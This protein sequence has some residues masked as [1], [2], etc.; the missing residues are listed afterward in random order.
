MADRRDTR[1]SYRS[2]P[3][4]RD[5][6]STAGSARD[7]ERAWEQR[8]Y[9]SGLEN[10]SPNERFASSTRQPVSPRPVV[11]PVRH[12]YADSSARYDVARNARRNAGV[13]SNRVRYGTEQAGEDFR[14]SQ[15]ARTS[16]QDFGNQYFGRDGSPNMGSTR[17]NR[18]LI[19]DSSL[20]MD[21][22]T[23]VR[24]RGSEVSD[25]LLEQ[26]RSRGNR[27]LSMEEAQRVTNRQYRAKHNARQ[28]DIYAKRGGN[29]WHSQRKERQRRT[30]VAIAAVAVL[31]VI[32]IVAVVGCMSK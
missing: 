30:I 21:K 1:S 19:N 5:S 6:A 24:E 4:W 17:G 7:T 27:P 2:Q 20:R 18:I 16:R 22:V 13:E 14:P 12:E 23:G 26:M 9:S 25:E 11:P 10:T 8:A 31:A 29:A 3:S 32:F 28:H 15:Y